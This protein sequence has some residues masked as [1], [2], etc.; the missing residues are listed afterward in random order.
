[1]DESSTKERNFDLLADA[2]RVE[3]PE[4]TKK[5]L[6]FCASPACENKLDERTIRNMANR[7][8]KFR[9]T[10]TR[11][12]VRNFIEPY[13][14][15]PASVDVD[16]LQDILNKLTNRDRSASADGG[17]SDSVAGGFEQAMAFVHQSMAENRGLGHWQDDLSG[18]YILVRRTSHGTSNHFYREPLHI[19]GMGDSSWLLS[20]YDGICKGF[21]VFGYSMSATVLTHWHRKS[22]LAV[23]VIM[24]LHDQ[25]QETGHMPGIMI[26]I[27]D[28][29]ARPVS[30]QVAL[31]Q[32]NAGDSRVNAWSACAEMS[33][34]RA[35]SEATSQLAER[36][37]AEHPLHRFYD[38]LDLAHHMK[39]RESDE[40]ER[41]FQQAAD[42][43]PG[44]AIL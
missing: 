41:I 26:R 8:I 22:E 4:L 18:H 1:M 20:N 31:Q 33:P 36:I 30:S 42:L 35:S 43:L 14:T 7:D 6:D 11:E 40:W 29:R 13:L 10:S 34:G 25:S 5:M 17:L 19:G 3:A 27:S 28:R 37:E 2:L 23:R 24:A 21:S 44:D 16:R 38:A 9:N 32:V 12:F 15:Q 39:C